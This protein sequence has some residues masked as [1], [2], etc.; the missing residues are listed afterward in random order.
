MRLIARDETIQKIEK[1]KKNLDPLAKRKLT[2]FLSRLSSLAGAGDKQEIL[3]ISSILDKDEE[4][5]A[6]IANDRFCF[7]FSF[8]KDENG[9]ELMKI[10]SFVDALELQA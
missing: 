4:F 1:V 2:E 3:K 7:V 6:A 10:V 9:D 8:D 5:R